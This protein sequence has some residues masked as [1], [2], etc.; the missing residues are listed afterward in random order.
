MPA[1]HLMCRRVLQVALLGLVLCGFGS[2]QVTLSLAPG[3]G[4]PGTNVTLNVS[5]SATAGN[6]PAGVQWSLGY[7][8]GDFSAVNVTAGAAATAAGKSLTC[9]SGGGAS[10]CVLWGLNSTQMSNGVV[11]SVTLTISPS[12]LSTTSSVSMTAGQSTLPAATA[13]STST[14]GATVTINQTVIPTLSTLTCNPTSLTPP[15]S[16]SCTVTIGSAAPAGGTVVGLG[17]NNGAVTVPGSVTVGAGATTANFTASTS[18]ITADTTAQVT[19]TLGAVSKSAQLSLVAP[20]T[21]LGLSCTPS[22]VSGGQTSVCSLTLNKIAL[23]GGFAINLTSSSPSALTVPPSISILSGLLG[24]T[25][26]ATASAVATTTPVTVTATGTLGVA[27][28][29]V[30]VSSSPCSIGL[31][32]GTRLFSAGGGSGTVGV[33]VGGGCNWTATTDSPS[34]ISFQNGANTGSGNGSFV[35]NV[36]TNLSRA[37]LGTVT[38]GN[39]SFK[40]ME[41]GSTSAPVFN[42]MPPSS[43]YFDYV[44]LMSSYGITAGCST[45]P[46]LYCPDTPVTRAQM[47]V[48]IVAAGMVVTGTPL[49][50]APTPYFQDM[51]DTSGYFPF[52]Q[53]IKEAGI[54]AGC[55][56]NPPLFCPDTSITQGQMAVF[57]ITSWMLVNNVSSFTNTTTP[58]FSDVPST[59]P[60]F[61]FI[62][63]MRDMGF[64]NGCGNGLYCDTAPVTRGEMSPMVIRSILGAP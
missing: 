25:F 10:R 9:T 15:A 52:V 51:A 5:L 33:S 61:R 39:Q 20:V 32:P 56:A 49:T 6:Q 23:L 31:T 18:A 60:F 36:S 12:T 42:D 26:N 27:T 1:F 38:V 46:P 35:F 55:S 8:A 58:Y 3:S 30:T 53:K 22:T 64:W 34:W 57:M 16:S 19:G 44:S 14:A 54:T 17:S 37:R 47:A 48:F 63:K 43:P 24:T 4:S 28:T 41:D 2:A 7:P 11:A 45:N 13:I 59:H 21:L 62:Q 29:T 50:Y 40:V